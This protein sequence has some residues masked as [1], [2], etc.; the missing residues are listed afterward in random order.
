MSETAL[1]TYAKHAAPLDKEFRDLLDTC[2]ESVS[3][4]DLRVVEAYWGL[5]DGS[6]RSLESIGRELGITRER[7]RQLHKRA[8]P[9]IRAAFL[10]CEP[11]SVLLMRE[12]LSERWSKET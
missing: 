3:P 11:P 2:G 12:L 1:S 4:R 8:A 7:V 6:P 10:S 5:C 9:N